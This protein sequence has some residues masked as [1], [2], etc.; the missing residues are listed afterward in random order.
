MIKQLSIYLLGF[1]E[2]SIK[3]N[4]DPR[5]SLFV[6]FVLLVCLIAFDRKNLF[7]K[8]KDRF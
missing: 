2:S 5:A 7:Q 4:I 3:S 8:T 1:T 6:I